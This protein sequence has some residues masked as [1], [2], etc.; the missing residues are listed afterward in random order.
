MDRST[1][2]FKAHP[3]LVLNGI[4]L[5]ASLSMTFLTF[6]KEG[7]HYYHD[8]HNWRALA[9][10]LA[11]KLYYPLL[12]VNLLVLLVM[13]RQHQIRRKPSILL[14]AAFVVFV[15]NV[16]LFSANNV[17]NIIEGKPLHS[18]HKGIGW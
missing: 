6:V 14:A 4:I 10:L 8:F 11:M 12:V 3:F 18:L 1:A 9:Y 13:A 5:V 7:G 17:I 16:G 15:V 2:C